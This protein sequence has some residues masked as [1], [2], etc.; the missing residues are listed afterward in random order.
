[1]IFRDAENDFGYIDP[2]GIIHWFETYEQARDAMLEVEGKSS[3]VVH[4]K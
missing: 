3:P 1:M 2:K 4:R